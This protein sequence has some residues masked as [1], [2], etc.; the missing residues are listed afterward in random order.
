MRRIFGACTRPAPA[1][2]CNVLLVRGIVYAR[3]R[4]RFGRDVMLLSGGG[5]GPGLHEVEGYDASDAFEI[6]RIVGHQD[7]PSFAAREGQK[8]IV[9]ERLR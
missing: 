4:L 7:N 5:H 2:P 8:N 9:A 6:M 3:W 1:Y